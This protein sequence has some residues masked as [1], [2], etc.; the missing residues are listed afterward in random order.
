MSASSP[1]EQSQDA[2]GHGGLG[3]VEVERQRYRELLG[4][5]R[6]ILPGVQVLF[7]FLLTAPFS[8]RFADLDLLGRRA[9]LVALVGVALAMILL[10]SPAAYHRLTDPGA[11][12]RR[13]QVSV[14]F[15]LA[16]MV[17]LGLAVADAVFVVTRFMFTTT[18]GVIVAGVVLASMVL[19]WWL[20]PIRDR[21][22][23]GSTP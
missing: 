17:I 2:P 15:Q 4:E 11:R 10:L 14:R 22:A 20:V 6:T 3:D 8:S 13:L 16:G 21:G 9:F 19:L 23:P 1:G 7:A 5:L 12:A 18:L